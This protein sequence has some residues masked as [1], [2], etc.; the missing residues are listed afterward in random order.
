MSGL[1]GIGQI[2]AITAIFAAAGAWPV[3]DVNETVYLPKARHAADPPWCAGDFFLET[4]DAHGFFYLVMGPVAARLP[5]ETAA[6][7]SR[8]A[9]W[10]AL[11]VGFRHLALPLVA[12][13]KQ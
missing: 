5:L 4:P 7:L 2:I 13:P 6:W 1:R 11:A 12:G 10:L 8:I 3:P 9:G